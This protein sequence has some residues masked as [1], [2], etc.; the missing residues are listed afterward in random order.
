MSDL[1]RLRYSDR[2]TN[3]IRRRVSLANNCTKV[4]IDTFA[5]VGA[6]GIPLLIF[7]RANTSAANPIKALKWAEGI[8]GSG[9]LPTSSASH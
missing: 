6:C 7:R 1:P 9:G 8:S 2:D 3:A 5:S 4:S